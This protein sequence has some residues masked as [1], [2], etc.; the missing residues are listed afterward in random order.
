MKS[1]KQ[2]VMQVRNKVVL[3][4]SIYSSPQILAELKI[5]HVTNRKQEWFFFQFQLMLEFLSMSKRKKEKELIHL[6]L[7]WFFTYYLEKYKQNQMATD[8]KGNSW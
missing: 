8:K 6:L 5:L 1:V 4:H 7:K 3:Y 2:V